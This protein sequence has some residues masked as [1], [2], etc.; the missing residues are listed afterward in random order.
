MEQAIDFNL[1]LG[2]A[3][4][5]LG[6]VLIVLWVALP[7]AVFRIKQR[8]DET[9][10]HLKAIVEQ[11]KTQTN[12][13]AT[14]SLDE[15]NKYLRVIVEL[16]RRQTEATLISKKPVKPSTGGSVT[17]LFRS[18]TKNDEDDTS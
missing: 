15:T 6:L 9:N 3:L 18:K 5:I 8:L 10:R 7:F 11:L 13:Q 14:S 12:A 4:G 1:L 2:I 17:R 16:L